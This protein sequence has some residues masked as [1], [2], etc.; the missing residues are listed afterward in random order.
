MEPVGRGRGRG[1][2]LHRRRAF[3]AANLAK[4][5][6]GG[7]VPLL[8]AVVVF[9][10]MW[11]WHRGADAVHDQAFARPPRRSNSFSPNWTLA[12]IPRVPGSAVFFT[13]TARGAPPVLI[14]HV[15]HNRALHEH[16]LILGDVHSAPRVAPK[17]IASCRRSS[18]PHFWRADARY[19]FMETPDVPVVLTQ[20][21]AWVATSISAT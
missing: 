10:V 20:T 14:W 2:V 9:G 12:R 5:L 18:A 4:V 8:L 17:P 11:I 6:D 1:R 13:R 3:F 19:G 15:K 16:V 7:Y 21:R